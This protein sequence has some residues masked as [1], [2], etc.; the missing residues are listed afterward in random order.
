MVLSLRPSAITKAETPA[1]ATPSSAHLKSATVSSKV[2]ANAV[3]R[4]NLVGAN[5]KPQSSGEDLQKGKVNYFIGKDPSKWHRNVPLY[6]QVDSTFIRGVDIISPE[7]NRA[8]SMT[9]W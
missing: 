1:S 5:S 2:P 9:S 8:L 7:I 4:M 6:R 3:I